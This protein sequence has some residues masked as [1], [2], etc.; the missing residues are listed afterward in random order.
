MIEKDFAANLPV[1]F[2][3]DEELCWDHKA[4][5]CRQRYKN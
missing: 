3:L 1:H 2:L 4:I 5:T